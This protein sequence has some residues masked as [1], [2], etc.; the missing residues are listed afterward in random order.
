M[1]KM[2]DTQ[3][4]ILFLMGSVILCLCALSI[5]LLP[6]IDTVPLD[7]PAFT[8]VPTAP[9]EPTALQHMASGAIIQCRI[10]VEDELLVPSSADFSNEKTYKVDGKPANYHAVIG[11]VTAQNR[12]GVPLRSNYR[13]DVHY[14]PEDPS[15]WV[16]DSL[17]ID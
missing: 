4:L 3:K 12:F 2:T 9:S 17:T 11:T 16:L 6:K 5:V 15:R 1:K 13:C 8:A 7:T 10:F 14:I